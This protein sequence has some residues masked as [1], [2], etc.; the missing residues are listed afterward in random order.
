MTLPQSSRLA[1]ALVALA[2]CSA[3][4]D[5]DGDAPFEARASALVPP[6]ALPLREVPLPTGGDPDRLFELTAAVGD[7][8]AGT[9][10]LQLVDTEAGWLVL[11]PDHALW[12]HGADTPTHVDDD[13]HAPVSVR[14]TRVAY[15]QGSVPTLEIAV[16]D[17]RR[18]TA[19]RVTGA[20]SPTWNPALGPEGDVAFVSSRS[21]RPAL[22]RVT[23]PGAP[24][25]VAEGGP[26][27]SSLEAPT[28]DGRE[29]HFRDEDGLSHTVS[30]AP[31]LAA[32]LVPSSPTANGALR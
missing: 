25:L 14:G 1:L 31:P 30:L 8:P 18:G 15:A 28:N 20:F 7:L 13:V 32:P 4:P 23:P 6:E 11:R 12:L 26:F 22:Y 16:A 21:G 9:R 2:A 24:R 3:D 10:V 5:P 17:L 29:L 27:P 19:E